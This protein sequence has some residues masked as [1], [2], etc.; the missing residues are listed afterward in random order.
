VSAGAITILL[1]L[2]YTYAG[3]PVVIGLL[4]P[5]MPGIEPHGGPQPGVCIV[6]ARI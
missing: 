4:A 6:D 3:Y 1:L 5:H 2:V